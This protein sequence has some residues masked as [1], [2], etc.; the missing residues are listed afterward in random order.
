MQLVDQPGALRDQ[1]VATLI[2]QRQ[3]RGHI[4]GLDKLRVSGE[5]GDTGRRG[6]VDHVVLPPAATGQFTHP[7]RRRRGHVLDPLPPGDQPLRQVAAQAAG[8][9]H[10][11]ALGLEGL[12]PAQQSAIAGQ[13]GL[14]LHRRR[15]SVATRLHRGGG[16]RVLVWI[17]SDDDHESP[18]PPANLARRSRTTRRLAAPVNDQPS[19]ESD[20]DPRHRPT[21]QTPE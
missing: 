13:R 17:Y 6:R 5:R 12:R 1:V 8:V 9:L 7:R 15:H 18:F 14:D 21:R 3:Q 20:R 19:V 10:R 16:M 2:E 11:P 4:L